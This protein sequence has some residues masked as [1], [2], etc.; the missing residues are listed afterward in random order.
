MRHPRIFMAEQDAGS[1]NGAAAPAVTATTTTEPQ[2]QGAAPAP[3]T[4]AVDADSIAAKVRD[5]LF[6][7]LRKA[8]VFEKTKAPQASP[9]ARKD[10]S[11]P[12][13]PIDYRSLDRALSKSGLSDRLSDAQYKRI[14]KAYAEEQP[15]DAHGWVK[16]YFDGLGV[17]HAP[18]PATATAQPA[19]PA[20]PAR[21]VAE[22]PVSTK[23]TP[24]A[25]KVAV[26]ELHLPS[27][28]DADIKEFI[29][30]K[31]MRTYVDTLNRQLR[32]TTVKLNG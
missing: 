30:Q 32:G 12:P 9:P 20:A 7:E 31:G 24:P 8:G 23:G 11:P 21:P 18:Q 2:A 29:R 13:Q 4:P 26:E 15:S 3:Q 19:Q 14:E 1:G 10:D 27:A 17:T 16:D 25:A 5:S 22:H 6:A 28:T